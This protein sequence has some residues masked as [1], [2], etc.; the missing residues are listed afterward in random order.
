MAVNWREWMQQT[1]PRTEIMRGG[2]TIWPAGGDRLLGDTLGPVM[3][4]HDGASEVYYFTAGRCRL[5]VGDTEEFFEAG[6]FTLLPPGTPHNFWNAGKEDVGL[7]WI[8]AP[9]FVEN[10]WRTENFTTEEMQR[11]IP[12]QS[13]HDYMG[14]VPELTLPSDENI[15]SRLISLDAGQDWCE[16]TLARQEAVLYVLEGRMQV[17]VGPLSGPLGANEFVHVGAQ[18]EY[19]LT[20]LDGK[21][22]ALVFRTPN[23]PS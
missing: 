14:K 13:V 20:A 9:H 22:S 7:F 18:K 17:Q 11:R 1:L 4:L 19:H 5:E 16:R 15:L 8:V 23:T 6:D 3:H 12:R 21:A 10:K 2:A